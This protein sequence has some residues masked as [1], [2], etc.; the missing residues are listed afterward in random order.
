MGLVS[1]YRHLEML[2]LLFIQGYPHISGRYGSVISLI[3]LFQ[4][5]RHTSHQG[6]LPKVTK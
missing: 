1:Y 6:F 2:A 4:M 5:K 3:T